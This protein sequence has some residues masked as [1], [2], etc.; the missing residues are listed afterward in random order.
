MVH[1]HGGGGNEG[2]FAF[3]LE[4]Q[5]FKLKLAIARISWFLLLVSI[6]LGIL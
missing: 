6:V 1:L 2:G 3:W 4:M 5:L